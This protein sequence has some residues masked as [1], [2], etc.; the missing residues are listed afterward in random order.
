MTWLTEW[1]DDLY[2]GV[3]EVFQPEDMMMVYPGVSEVF[4]PEDMM[5]VYPGV[6]EV[7]PNW[8]DCQAR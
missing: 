3:S 8:S 7:S 4:Q 5:M 6:S 2:P 1:I